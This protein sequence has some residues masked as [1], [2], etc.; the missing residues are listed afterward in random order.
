MWAGLSRFP[1]SSRCLV[2]RRRGG[3]RTRNEISPK[4]DIPLPSSFI[5]PFSFFA[6]FFF[7]LPC[8]LQPLKHLN[9]GR[10]KKPDSAAPWGG[11]D[12]HVTHTGS[13][14]EVWERNVQ[15]ILGEGNASSDVQRQHFRA[16]CY[17]E[18]EGPREVCSRLHHLYRQWLKPE[19]HTKAQML[20]L[21]VFEQFLTILPPDMESWVR[22]CGAET[23]S[24]AVALAEG[25]LLS[26][27]EEKRQEEKEQV[28]ALFFKSWE[29]GG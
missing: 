27:V 1:P 8:S 21:V 9:F 2:G 14:G 18:A 23:S 6:L 26:Q 4:G 28:R 20:D 12:P 7:L 19:K 13:T 10:W 5:I 11:K 29:Y 25:F 17:Q 22:E 16:F 24:Q 15:Q 3:S